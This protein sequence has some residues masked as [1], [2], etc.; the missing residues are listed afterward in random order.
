MVSKEDIAA[1]KLNVIAGRGSKKDFIDLDF[2]LNE[3][4]LRQIL[5][6]YLKNTLM[7]QNLWF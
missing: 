4:S 1:M 3:F 2:L 6:F 5:D 7:V